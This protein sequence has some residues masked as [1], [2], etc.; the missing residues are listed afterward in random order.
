[1]LPGGPPSFPSSNCL[2]VPSRS[3]VP[4][5]QSSASQMTHSMDYITFQEV[6][7][8]HS[9]TIC[10]ATRI[11]P[12]RN[13]KRNLGI[14]PWVAEDKSTAHKSGKHKCGEGGRFGLVLGSL[15]D[16]RNG[17]WSSLLLISRRDGWGGFQEVGCNN[18]CKENS[19]ESWSE[20][21]SADLIIS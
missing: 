9:S 6:T 4:R 17:E 8:S 12:K 15:R 10:L 19:P 21:K 7:S 5:L 18:R 11:N 3:W 13:Y 1:M 20:N 16:L 14:C 2:L